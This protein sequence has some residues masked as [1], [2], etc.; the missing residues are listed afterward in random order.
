MVVVLMVDQ[1]VVVLLMIGLS[2]Y[3]GSLFG[4]WDE[5]LCRVF[6]VFTVVMKVTKG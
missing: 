5:F 3:V 4:I 6:W 1:W 2:F